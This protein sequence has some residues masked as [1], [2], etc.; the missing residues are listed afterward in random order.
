MSYFVN[1]LQN[2]IDETCYIGYTQDLEARLKRHN[3]GRSK[4]TKLNRPWKLIYYEEYNN[5]AY[6]TM[7]EKKIKD[8]KSRKWIEDLAIGFPPS[9]IEWKEEA[10][11]EN[12]TCSSSK[13]DRM[14]LPLIRF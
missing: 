11:E 1:I 14:V 6:A 12:I 7:Q 2:R 8:H 9:L 13:S 3:E 5:R 4:Y 10:Y